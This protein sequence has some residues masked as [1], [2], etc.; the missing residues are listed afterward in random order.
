MKL[1]QGSVLCFRGWPDVRTKTLQILL[2]SLQFTTVL[3]I[4]AMW[5]F[6][7]LKPSC[8]ITFQKGAPNLNSRTSPKNTPAICANGVPD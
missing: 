3:S 4:G 1:H 8:S 5:S 7:Y 6:P 2:I